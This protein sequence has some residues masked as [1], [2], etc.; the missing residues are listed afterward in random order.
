MG[1]Q[2]VEVMVEGGKATPSPPL[3]PSL[4]PTGINI[5]EVVSAINEKT[6]DLAG[7]QVPVKV[8][9]DTEKKTFSL[10]VGSPPVASLVKKELSLERGSAE[11]GKFRVGDLTEEQVAKIAR[12]K[13]GS[14]GE[15]FRNQVKGTCRSMGVTI[16]Q[17]AVTKD[18]LK[19][20]EAEKARLKAEEEAKE[21]AAKLREAGIAPEAGAAPEGEAP[22]GE[23]KAEEGAKEGEP[24]PGEGEAKAEGKKEKKE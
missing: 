24:K 16:G 11:A 2:T 6:R 23:A 21:E 14:D 22:E 10:E 15:G 19:A 8:I 7:M 18:E 12:A 3:G 4:A 17:G 13:F 5:G 9:V 1:K 20:Q